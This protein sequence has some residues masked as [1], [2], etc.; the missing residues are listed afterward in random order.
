[1]GTLT[2]KLLRLRLLCE[3][4]LHC[5]TYMETYNRYLRSCGF[6]LQGNVKYIH[7]SVY[8]DIGYASNIHIGDNCVISVNSIILAHDYSLECGMASIGLGDLEN[9]KKIVCD[10]YIGRNVFVGAGCIIL[11]GTQIGDNCIIGAGTV[12]SGQIPENSV[13]VGN[14]WRS[15][16]KTNEWTN[17]KIEMSGGCQNL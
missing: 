6:D 10:V 1:M 14:T 2:R 5:K 7:S 8:L 12:C 4:A 9:E 15:I 11:P 3:T 17:K 13:I 16:A